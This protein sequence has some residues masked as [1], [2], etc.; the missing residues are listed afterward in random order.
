MKKSYLI[1]YE[2]R[3]GYIL[4]DGICYDLTIK[5]VWL[6]GLFERTSNICFQVENHIDL[7]SLL[8]QWDKL[9]KDKT[10]LQ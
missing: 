3:G 1:S 4:L 10:I 7:S 8:K 6:W 5:T 2:L 9:I